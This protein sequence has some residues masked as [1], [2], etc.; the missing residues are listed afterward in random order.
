M[1]R[2]LIFGEG[3]RFHNF[4]ILKAS[5]SLIHRNQFLTFD[6]K[7]QESYVHVKIFSSINVNERNCVSAKIPLLLDAKLTNRMS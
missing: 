1:V 6:L 5:N 7:V 4:S 2:N 3:F